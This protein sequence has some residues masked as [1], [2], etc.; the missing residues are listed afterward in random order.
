MTAERRHGICHGRG[1]TGIVLDRALIKG[2]ALRGLKIERA[3]K[4]HC[5]P[6]PAIGD[7][8]NCN[9]R[10]VAACE[11][12]DSPRRKSRVRPDIVDPASVAGPSR[13]A[14]WTLTGFHL[15]PGSLD[16]LQVIEA[17]SRLG[18]RPN[19]LLGII[20]AIA[21]PGQPNLAACHENFADR[22]QQL[23]LALGLK[24]RAGALTQRPQPSVEPVQNRLV[25]FALLLHDIQ[26]TGARR[27]WIRTSI[28]TP[29]VLSETQ[30]GAGQGRPSNT[31][32]NLVE[33]GFSSAS[34][35]DA[36]GGKSSVV[37]PSQSIRPTV[38][39]R[40]DDTVP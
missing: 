29:V 25:G 11:G 38:F 34:R 7:Q 13:N 16:A 27:V 8:W 5:A 10:S 30:H 12:G 35:V 24:E 39:S 22:L 23:L 21:N 1:Q 15:A 9:A 20:F 26:L 3:A 2:V 37:R 19:G 36:E 31:G 32:P 6:R 18:H 4:I 17:V 33:R 40:L 14:G 28:R